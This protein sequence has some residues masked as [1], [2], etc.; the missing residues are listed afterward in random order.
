MIL[1]ATISVAF[2]CAK[3]LRIEDGLL[4]GGAKTPLSSIDYWSF[5]F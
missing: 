4:R 3:S 1:K 2:F 5:I